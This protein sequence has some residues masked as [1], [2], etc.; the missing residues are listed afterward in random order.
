MGFGE[1]KRAA[2]LRRAEERA[3][4]FDSDRLIG[5]FATGR[6]ELWDLGIAR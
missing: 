2:G 4:F 5:E 1:S 6:Y 3:A